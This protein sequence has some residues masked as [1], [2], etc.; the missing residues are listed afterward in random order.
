MKASGKEPA[1]TLTTADRCHSCPAR[2]AVQTVMEQGRSLPWCTHHF[3][4][5]ENAVKALGVTIGSTS[6]AGSRSATGD[7]ER[8]EQSPTRWCGRRRRFPT[9]RLRHA[10]D[11]AILAGMRVRP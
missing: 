11:V 10:R 3:A 1:Q 2:A 8:C 5:V 6:G 4:H 7:R 9:G